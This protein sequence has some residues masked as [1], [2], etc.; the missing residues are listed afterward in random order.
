VATFKKVLGRMNYLCTRVDGL[1]IVESALLSTR[2]QYEHLGRNYFKDWDNNEN[3][4]IPGS[5][6]LRSE[7][8]IYVTRAGEWYTQDLV[9]VGY[10][11]SRTSKPRVLGKRVPSKVA[12]YRVEA[13]YELVV[14]REAERRTSGLAG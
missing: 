4:E 5:N 11:P 13:S 8:F 10:E 12:T 3:K 14:V 9:F 2:S 1:R 7:P 6:A